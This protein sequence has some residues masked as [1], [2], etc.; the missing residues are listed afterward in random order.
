MYDGEYLSQNRILK[1][2][3]EQRIVGIEQIG[4]DFYLCELCDEYYKHKLTK[5][6][7]CG[8]IQKRRLEGVRKIICK[9]Q[10]WKSIHN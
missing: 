6:M 8:T 7:A 1:E 5:Q 3:I 9:N 2:L 10:T 4:N